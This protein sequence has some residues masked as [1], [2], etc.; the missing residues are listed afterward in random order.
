MDLL[1]TAREHLPV[2]LV[3]ILP[4]F[5]SMRVFELLV[6]TRSTSA[7]REALEALSYGA[8]NFG[9]WAV[10]VLHWLPVLQTRPLRATLAAILILIVSPAALALGA[11]TLLVWPFLRRWVVHPV[12]TAW[13]HFFGLR[14]A[15]WMRIHLKNGRFI[16]GWYGPASFAGSDPEWRDLYVEQAWELDPHS[17]GFKQKIS[18]TMGFLVR[19]DDCELIEILSL[20]QVQPKQEKPKDGKREEHAE[21][22]PHNP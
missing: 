6:P 1:T 2:L 14:K 5:I 21:Q 4:G 3:L 22:R 16:G 7:G 13:D 18:D 19:M 8:L 11:R 9:I 10:P 20:S 15:A 17:G 12:P